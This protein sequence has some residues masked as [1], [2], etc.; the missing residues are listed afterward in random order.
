MV[1]AGGGEAVALQWVMDN[2]V[3]PIRNRRCLT[4]GQLTPEKVEALIAKYT[5]NV[6]RGL[7]QSAAAA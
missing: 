4:E 6:G 5:I 2:D 1:E 3:Q 7:R